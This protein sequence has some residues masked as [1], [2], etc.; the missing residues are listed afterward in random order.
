VLLAITISAVVLTVAYASFFQIV[1]SKDMTEETLETYH[2]AMVILSRVTQDVSMTFVPGGVY[3]Q[4]KDSATPLFIGERTDGGSALRFASFSSRPGID[5]NWS[6]EIEVFYHLVRN[7]ER[8]EYSLMR[9]EN[10]AIGMED[11][12]IEY[13]LSERVIY[14]QLSYISENEDTGEIEILEEW[15][16]SLAG[17]LPKAVEVKF[18]LRKPGGEA[19]EFSS[20][21]PIPTAN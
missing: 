7:P 19:A 9:R 5:S 20:L 18:A 10:P 16:S 4:S 13:P 12:G 11:S 1:K 15:D 6:D 21:I 3:T 17:T 2:E 14:F 8:E